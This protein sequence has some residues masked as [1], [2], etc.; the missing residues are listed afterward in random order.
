MPVRGK[1]HE[2]L[3]SVC[4][5]YIRAKTIY[6]VCKGYSPTIPHSWNLVIKTNHNQHVIISWR[7]SLPCWHHYTTFECVYTTMWSRWPRLSRAC[8][9]VPPCCS[10]I[11]NTRE[12]QMATK[13][14]WEFYFYDQPDSSIYSFIWI[15]LCTKL[16]IFALGQFCLSSGLLFI[17]R[18]LGRKVPRRGGVCITVQTR[19]TA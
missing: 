2:I 19:V 6:N 12:V 16:T 7:R 18:A 5:N 14:K 1:C 9:V 11:V 3:P 13:S 15:L 8:F 10:Q 17:S 4:K